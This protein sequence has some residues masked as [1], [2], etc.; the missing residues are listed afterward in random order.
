MRSY[1]GCG[2]GEA[3]SGSMCIEKTEITTKDDHLAVFSRDGQIF[4]DYFEVEAAWF[5]AK[6]KAS[7]GN[8]VNTSNPREIQIEK[9]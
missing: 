5:A 1:T 8:R 3:N 4:A 6:G 9:F 2:V 7:P